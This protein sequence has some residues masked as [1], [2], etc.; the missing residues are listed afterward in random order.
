MPIG[1][2]KMRDKTLETGKKTYIMGILN[3]TPD[4]FSDGGMYNTLDKGMERALKMIQDG[5]DM[6]DI[7]GESSRPG[8]TPVSA[9]EEL[10]RIMPIVKNLCSNTETIVSIDTMK[11]NVAEECLKIGAHIIND[12][13]GLQRDHDMARVVADYGAGIVIMHNKDVAEYDDVVKE[14][15]KFLEKSIDIALKAGI[16]NENIMVDPG[17]GFGKNL[18][19]NLTLMK[20]LDE[21]KCLGLPILLGTS[22]KSMIGKVL[23][24]DVGERV[25]GTAATVSVGIVKGADIVR[26]HDVKEMH[27]VAMMTDAIVR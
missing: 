14:V 27:R 23:N 17:I 4:S 12:I 5:A 15:I 24:L 18:E 3:M 6:I 21:L 13:W 10:K 19:H 26:V 2:L 7:G 16:K 9:E 20:R 11:S 1:I 22:R 8:Y 25:E